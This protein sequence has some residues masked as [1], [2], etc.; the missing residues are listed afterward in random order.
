M[1]KQQ[2]ELLTS[3]VEMDETF[4]GPRKLR[5]RHPDDRFLGGSGSTKQPVVG[6]VQR[7]GDVIAK[8]GGLVSCLEDYSGLT[9]LRH[10]DTKNLA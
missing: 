6:M 2:R 9:Y 10:I 5:K 4:V 8:M 1:Q 3:V 7:D